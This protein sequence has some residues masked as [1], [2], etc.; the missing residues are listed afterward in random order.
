MPATRVTRVHAYIDGWNFYC[1][2]NEPGR[3]RY[4]WCNF[5]KLADALSLERFGEKTR[6]VKYFTT[7][8]EA[9][10]FEINEG[11]MERSRI[12]FRA[13]QIVTKLEPI[14]GRHQKDPR[15]ITKR[16]EKETD[17]HLAVDMLS[18]ASQYEAALLLSADT[19]FR[20]LIR[21][22]TAEREKTIVVCHLEKG[23]EPP[24]TDP[25]IARW[26]N[27][28]IPDSL[29]EGCR[30]PD[31]IRDPETN[32]LLSWSHYLALKGGKFPPGRI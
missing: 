6:L 22:L 4:G 5:I 8:V 32:E 11:E 3:L 15:S 29:L 26:E 1:G 21:K 14:S 30:L 2:I 9:K 28:S 19:D 10:K 17:V 20:P 12:W 27:R 25:E 18:N 16:R 13:L 31:E 24:A 7:P 23:H